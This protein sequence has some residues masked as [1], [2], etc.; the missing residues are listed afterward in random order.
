MLMLPEKKSYFDIQNNIS[1]PFNFIVFYNLW[2]T[3]LKFRWQ[4]LLKGSN[5]EIQTYSETNSLE[6]FSVHEEHGIG[7]RVEQTG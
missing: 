4:Q 5:T 2:E 7:P 6:E 1:L 3:L